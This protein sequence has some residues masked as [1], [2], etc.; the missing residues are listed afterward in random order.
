LAEDEKFVH[1]V[2]YIYAYVNG[3]VLI[4]IC[5]DEAYHYWVRYNHYVIIFFILVIIFYF[6]VKQMFIRVITCFIMGLIMC[7][8]LI[9]GL[10]IR[11][12]LLVRRYNEQHQQYHLQESTKYNDSSIYAKIKSLFKRYWRKLK[13]VMSGVSIQEH[14]QFN[15]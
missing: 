8:I 11:I 14:H 15:V 9:V 12:C 4:G 6:Q 2:A 7:G 10:V 5:W 13:K 3:L 1:I